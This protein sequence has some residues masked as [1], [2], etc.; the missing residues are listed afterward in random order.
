[1]QT[2]D[3]ISYFKTFKLWSE[4]TGSFGK[5]KVYLYTYE[6]RYTPLKA[7]TFYLKCLKQ[8]TITLTR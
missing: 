7:N 3:I 2:F 5:R 4:C 8:D 6:I 1:V